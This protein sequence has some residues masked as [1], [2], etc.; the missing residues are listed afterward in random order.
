M[1]D[2]TLSLCCNVPNEVSRCS[3]GGEMDD[4][5]ALSDEVSNIVLESDVDLRIY[6][7]RVE[8]QLESLESSAVETSHGNNIGR[9]SPR[10]R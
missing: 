6:S 5:G 7:K 10:P 3:S 1:A 8:E 2:T 9:F 4:I